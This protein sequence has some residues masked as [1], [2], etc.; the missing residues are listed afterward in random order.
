MSNS[1]NIDTDKAIYQLSNA[2]IAL[3][4]ALSHVNPEITQ[5]YLAVAIE[6]SRA[7]G[8]GTELIEEIYSKVFP[9]AKPS[10]VLSPEEFAKKQGG[11]SQ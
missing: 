6:G 1:Y 7:A 10:V 8:H 3:T 11:L 9:N 2:V 4:N 5:G